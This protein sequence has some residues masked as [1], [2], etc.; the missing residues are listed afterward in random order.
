MKTIILIDDDKFV[1]FSFKYFFKNLDSEI[2]TFWNVDEFMDRYNLYPSSAVIFVDSD[3]KNGTK[4]EI[5]SERIFKLG[6][7][8]LFLTTGFS[9][10]H[11]QKPYWIIDIL[12]KNPRD[13]FT[14][15]FE[16]CLIE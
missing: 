6:F 11:F 2:V 15:D 3:L 4:G 7:K 13:F 12:P 1:H 14:A 8:N 5:E 10:D 9:K 16:A